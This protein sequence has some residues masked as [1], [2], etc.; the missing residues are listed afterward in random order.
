MPAEGRSGDMLALLECRSSIRAARLCESQWRRRALKV[1]SPDALNARWP[2]S[3]RGSAR[4]TGN[5]PWRWSRA[6]GLLG[7]CEASS[8]IIRPP[9]ER[10]GRSLE[11]AKFG[12]G[13]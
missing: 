12:D 9:D 11:F 8:P 7:W 1:V 2:S 10:K 13:V 3:S 4:A 6:D 5:E